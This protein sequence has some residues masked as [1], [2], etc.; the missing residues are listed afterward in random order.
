[1]LT[2]SWFE[3]LHWKQPI[4]YGCHNNVLSYEERLLY[5]SCI[6]TVSKVN[7]YIVGWA[8]AIFFIWCCFIIISGLNNRGNRGSVH[9][10]VD[11]DHEV[12]LQP[13]LGNFRGIMYCSSSLALGGPKWGL[14]FPR[15]FPSPK[16]TGICT[17]HAWLLDMGLLPLVQL[18]LHQKKDRY[19]LL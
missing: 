9:H 10:S 19:L 4:G 15:Y 5:P 12:M 13:V 6:C 16:A 14:D 17:A 8:W 1:M 3:W 7:E 11:P 18:N 2:H